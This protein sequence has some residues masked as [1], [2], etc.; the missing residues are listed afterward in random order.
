MPEL[1]LALERVTLPERA[2]R[3]A[4]KAADFR[5]AGREEASGEREARAD[6][7]VPERA[8][9][10]GGYAKLER[11]DKAAATD[12]PRELRQ[13]RTRFVD[14]AE[15]I[16]EGQ[17][18]EGAVGEWERFGRGLDELYA[19][20]EA[21]VCHGEHLGALIE[22][23]NA[24]AAPEELFCHEA[25]P[26]RDV[27][28][29]TSSRQARDEKAAPERILSEREDGAD[30]VVGRRERSKELPSVEAPGRHP[31]ILAR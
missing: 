16:R 12:D 6:V 8:N 23:R 13:G 26:R 1:E 9:G 29:V 2:N 19:P 30:A 10:T 4:E 20:A 25:S 22:P 5:P 17:V 21:A 3:P 11:R 27:E 24:K 18:V 15:E 7:N 14:V 31:S 28:D